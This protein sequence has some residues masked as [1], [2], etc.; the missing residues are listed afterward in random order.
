VG[1][2]QIELL[3]TSA[4]TWTKGKESFDTSLNGW[5]GPALA[6]LGSS[7]APRISCDAPINGV[8]LGVD[9][10][11]GLKTELTKTYT[12][13]PPHW[14]I[15]FRF[16]LAYLNW[17]TF[18]NRA[19]MLLDNAMVLDAGVSQSDFNSD[20]CKVPTAFKSY[21]VVVPDHNKSTA[22]LRLFTTGTYALPVRL[23]PARHCGFRHPRHPRP[24]AL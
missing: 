20:A 17:N 4:T 10:Y 15:V 9:E 23:P 3:D 1:Y 22:S 2:G 16:K 21:S 13:L 12:S 14:G 11:T 18:G 24:C 6:A 7:P 5:V 19:Q 8:I